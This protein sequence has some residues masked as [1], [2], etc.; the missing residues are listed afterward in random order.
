MTFHTKIARQKS[1]GTSYRGVMAGVATINVDQR[2]IIS[3]KALLGSISGDWIAVGRDL[4]RSIR[5]VKDELE[6]A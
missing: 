1:R 4:S 6:S 2:L 5:Q 3:R